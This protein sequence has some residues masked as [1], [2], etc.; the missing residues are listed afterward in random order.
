M[1]L[2]SFREDHISQ[3]P[4]IQLLINLGWKYISPA[5]AET[6][7]RGKSLGVL[8]ENI[9]ENQLRKLNK[10]RYKGGVYDFSDA[11]IKG[12][13]NTLKGVPF[14]GLVRTSEKLYD[15]LSLGKSFEQ[16]IEGDKK[17]FSLRYIDWDNFDNNEFHVSEEFS[18]ERRGRNDSCRPDI[19]L[20]INGIPFVVI[21]CKRPD[22][23]DSL[24][25]AIS[26][27]L[28]NQHADYIPQLFAFSQMLIAINKNEAM[29]ATTNTL[30]KFWSVWREEEDA[31]D[32]VSRIINKP[33][34]KADKDALF[35]D[36]NR[37]GYVREYFDKLEAEGRL[38][39]EQD[40][41]LWSLCQRKRF[42]ELVYKFIIF[43]AGVKKI[44]RYQQYFTVLSTIDRLKRFAPDGHREGGVV[45]HTQGS[46]KSL[47][48]VMLAKCI[49]LEPEIVNPKIILVT[50][51]TD[52]DDQIYG[53]FRACGKEPVKAKTGEDLLRKLKENKEAI[54][55]TT[56]FKFDKVV[57]K[58]KFSDTNPNIFVLVDESHRTQYKTLHIQMR[59]VLP[60]ACYIAFTGTPLMK[61]EKN[62]AQK[63]GGFI[64]PAYTMSDAVN[65][66]AVVPLLYEGRHIMQ[67][68]D[69]KAIDN[70]FEIVTKKL[71][72]SQKA[73]L[74][75][76][77]SSADEINKTNDRLQMIA[78]DISEHFSQ[79]FKGTPFKGQLVAPNKLSAIK[80]KKYLDEF[81]QVTSELL[82]SAP[83][84]REGN[85]TVE[86]AGTDEVQTFWK[87][88]MERFGDEE[89]YNKSLINSFK[90]G[91]EPEIII[92]VS[93][94]TT[95]FDAPRNTVLYLTRK[96]EGHELLQTI[97]RV[98]RLYDGKDYGFIIDYY[99]V[100]SYLGK[101]LKLYDALPEFD[102]EDLAGALTDIQEEINRL[103][104][105]HSD[106]WDIFKTVQ[107][108]RDE[109]AFERHL[110][111]EDVR[112][113]FYDR[114]SAFNRSL[115]VAL[116]SINFAL[117]TDEKTI[118]R[119]K[120]DL[121]FFQ[122]LR[123]S[124]RQRYSDAVDYKE[125]EAKVQNLINKHVSATEVMQL[126]EQ[127]NIFEKD[128]FQ[129][130]V[131][132]RETKA[133]KA[134]TI[135]FRLKK[136]ISEKIKEDPY[137]YRRFSQ[138]LQ[139]AIDAFRAGRISE[140]EYL[141]Q[142]T[143]AED[144]IT[145]REDKAYPAILK[146]RDRAKAYFN[147]VQAVKGNGGNGNGGGLNPDIAAEIALEIDT[148]FT[149][150]MV[151]DWWRNDDV[152]KEIK[153]QIDDY[154]FSLKKKQGIEFSFDELDK[155]I[156]ESLDIAKAREIA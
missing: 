95:G 139:D 68:V 69:Q 94:L 96:M 31:T 75:R 40:K 105:Y 50:D 63:F 127:V 38:P 39:T 27:H 117:Q 5:K 11:N 101:A 21:E 114:F 155:I 76:K 44:A 152:Q 17:S 10:I 148:I 124:V 146:N 90:N 52:L 26:Q 104:Q 107:G 135:A 128:K 91:E 112:Q 58:E 72:E 122:K 141:N 41:A 92:V 66:K 102:A 147:L 48:M 100:I 65:D 19:V 24:E 20:F 51:R 99:G 138:I 86:N 13:I 29:Y 131:E 12:A 81:G 123:L 93:K 59:K 37:F 36:P 87:Q 125:Y 57:K 133:A 118:A 103:P 9:L 34:T 14:D 89:A 121:L 70:W 3:I 7:R 137:F 62:T 45:W 134:D 98:N 33:L 150:N 60:K 113:D 156:E 64:E 85:E 151:V 88:M 97:A 119:Y 53:T 55:T 77:F 144:A 136:T 84:T 153:N 56:V 115:G 46:G 132:R 1:E 120:R 35:A 25:V 143:E 129:A 6:E 23:K 79:N 15:L 109:E 110:F 4:A 108:S 42:L 18:V 80:L 71:T 154:L 28:R 67:E 30:K 8:L 126:T 83:D 78:Y 2:P 145:T 16:I 142:V 73:D 32:E 22:E 49:A 61:A 116:S 54:I 130:E 149:D 43:D 82:I 47:T 74:K 111:P 140:L 106:L